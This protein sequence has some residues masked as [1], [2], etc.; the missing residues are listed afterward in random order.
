MR[1]RKI[2]FNQETLAV[3]HECSE[4]SV[5]GNITFPEVVRKL[6]DVGIEQYHADLYRREKTYYAANGDSHVE[7]ESGLDPKIFNAGAVAAELNSA[8]VKEALRRI[9]HKEVDYQ[10]FLRDIL[11]A[12]VANYWV[13]IAGKRAI[14]VARNGDEYVEWFPG[15]R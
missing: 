15:A 12:G 13:Y 10:Q 2:M 9:Q 4:R 6:I 11:A 3:L 14:Y 5:A 7:S 1:Q 8:G